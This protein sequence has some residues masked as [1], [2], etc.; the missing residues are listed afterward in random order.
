MQAPAV[1]GALMTG[2]PDATCRD[3][4]LYQGRDDIDPM[5]G[6]DGDIL[7][8]RRGIA[9]VILGVVTDRLVT[10]LVAPG[11]ESLWAAVDGRLGACNGAGWCEWAFA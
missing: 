1:A 9:G 5:Q 7:G 3:D 11:D 10:G 8:G 6:A 4:R 2:A